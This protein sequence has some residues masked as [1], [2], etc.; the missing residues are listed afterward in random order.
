ADRLTA[1]K[2]S[3]VMSKI[4]GK[5]TIPE[6]KLRAALE[7]IGQRIETHPQLPG[8]PDIIISRS[9]VAIFVHGCFWHG[10]P[11]HYR[12]PKSRRAYWSGKLA[13]NVARDH[14][15]AKALRKTGWTVVTVWECQVRSDSEAVASAVVRV[16]K[17]VSGA[18]AV[19]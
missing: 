5:D 2:R 10:C 14:K 4:K 16:V 13:R 17:R 9:M 15:V 11:A 1:S 19:R 18:D 7:K 3:E 12:V 8:R 6:R